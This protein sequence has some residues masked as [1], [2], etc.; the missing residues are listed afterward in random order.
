MPE[1]IPS[2][3]WCAPLPP[4][5]DARLARWL[6]DGLAAAK[7]PR[8]VAVFFRADDVGVP[9]RRFARL[10]EIFQRHRAPLGLAVVPAWLTAARWERLAALTRGG[11]GLWCWHQ[12]GWRHANHEP[13]GKKQE[14]GPARPA[15]RVAADLRRGRRRLEALMG[16]AFYPAFTPPWNR[17][18]AQALALIRAAGYRAVSRSS[19]SR[20]PAPP[21]LPELAVNLDLHTRREPSAEG[22]WRM[23]GEELQAAVAAGR[24]GIMIH[25]QRMNAAAAAFL[26]ALLAALKA[27]G[28]FRLAGMPALAENDGRT[29]NGRTG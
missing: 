15:A 4:N 3:I 6:A 27:Q 23:L 26:D 28:G 11:A 2:A 25:H 5:L 7:A 14:F 12:H 20:P 13:E 19:G 16:P 21:G 22:A 18:S 24:C 17:C 8:P 10:V 1:P 9:G 29:A